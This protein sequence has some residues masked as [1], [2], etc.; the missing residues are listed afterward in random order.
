MKTWIW[1]AIALLGTFTLVYLAWVSTPVEPIP[2][3][4]QTSKT[5]TTENVDWSNPLSGIPSGEEASEPVEPILVVGAPFPRP[6]YEFEPDLG[7]EARRERQIPSPRPEA[8][9]TPI[10]PM[11][12]VTD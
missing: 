8:M 11:P 2:A 10:R 3:P 5:T 6:T 9:E 1:G 4:I 12:P 7:V